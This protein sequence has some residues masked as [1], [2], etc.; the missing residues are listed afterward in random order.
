MDI[1]SSSDSEDEVIQ[2]KGAIKKH[3]FNLKI[4]MIFKIFH[5]LKCK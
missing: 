4:G 2:T 5:E 3:R 1:S